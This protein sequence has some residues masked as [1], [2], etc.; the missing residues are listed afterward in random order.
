MVNG[1]T[2]VPLVALVVGVGLAMQLGAAVA[3][4][5]RYPRWTL[6]PAS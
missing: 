6:T 1:G 4:P 2:V 5:V 3:A